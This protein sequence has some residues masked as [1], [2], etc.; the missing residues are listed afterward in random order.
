[1][2]ALRATGV[3]IPLLLTA[4][5]SAQPARPAAPSGSVLPFKASETTLPNGLKV[6]VVPTGFPNLVTMQI[7]VQTGSRNEVEPGK[8]GFAHFFEHLMFRGTPNT[9]PEKYRR[10]MTNAGARENA[11]TGDDFTRYYATFAKEDLPTMVETYADM[12]QNLSYAEG[13]FKTEARAILGEYNKNSAEPLQKLFEVQ[14]ERFYQAHT[15]KH[16]TMGFIKDIENMPNEYEYSKLFFQRWYR[17][18]FTTL[19]VAGD[20]TPEQVLPLVEKYWGG[21]TAGAPSATEIPKEPAPKAAQYVH[22]PWPS[23][24]LPWVTVGYLG[25]AFDEHS[26][27]TPA[28]DILAALYFGPTSDLYKRLVVTEQKVDDLGVDT[29]TGVDPSLFTVLARVK[30]PR[31][32]VYVRDQIMATL[33][34]SRAALVPAARLADAKSF[35]KYGFARSL[36][37]TERIA[38]VLSSFAPYRRSFDTVN[39]YYRTLDTLTPQD[40]QAAARTY[41]VDNSLVVATLSKDPLPAGIEPL[42]SLDAIKPAAQAA[43]PESKPAVTP[44]PIAAEAGAGA[45]IPLVEQKSAMPQLDVKLLFNVGSA[46]DPAGKE[47]LAALTAAMIAEAGSKAL[48]IDQ[49]QAALYPMAGSLSGRADKEMTTFTAVIHRDNWRPFLAVVLPQ[50]LEPGFRDQDF[51][52][53]KEDQLNALTQDLRSNNEE[54]LG[55]ERLQTNIFRGTPYGHVALGTVSGINAIAL[56]DVQDFAHRMYTRANLTLGVNGD[57]PAEMLRTVQANL[58]KL[59]EGPAAAKATVRVERASGINVEI[60]EKDTRATAIS[61][62][63]PTGVTRAH[64][65]FVALSVARVWLGEHRASSGRLYDRIRQVR[66]MN[67][68]DYAYIEAFPRGMFQF[69]PDPNVARQQQIFEIWIRP[70]VPV[71]AHMSLRIAIYELQKLVDKGLTPADFESARM[72]LM[73]NVYVMTA[74]QDQ[75]LGYALDSRWYGIGEF[76]KYMRDALQKLTVEQVN[77]AVRKH[78]AA[79]DLSIVYITKDAAALKQALVSDALSPIKYDADKPQELLDED[80]TIGAMKLNI[81]AENVKITP[82]AD[83]FVR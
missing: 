66:G 15:Y 41:F 3:I 58:A 44:V 75:Q 49:I 38:A 55:K 52:R 9:P 48:T 57:V 19:I 59:P 29:P 34:E 82:I 69:F 30:N 39:N 42:P 10:I 77:A 68:G 33:A 65:D 53:L 16:T 40:L 79:K 2:R 62:G 70:V 47:G 27:E 6:I 28:M 8:S 20:V 51:K 74:R 45:G 63:F 31:D 32:A 17:P 22:V 7:P 81:G 67:Y 14:R 37:S 23:D 5:L 4:S 43:T 64:P 46:H 54:E 11:S 76:T 56:A 36:D 50:L 78:L 25:P 18:Q 72:Y 73:K 21:W 80:K 13:D 1:M 12:F 24:T 60:L 26:K 83:V 61:F 71:N 35:N